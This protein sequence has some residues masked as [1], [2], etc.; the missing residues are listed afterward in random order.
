[1]TVPAISSLTYTYLEDGVTTVFSYPVRFLEASELL[2]IREAADGVRTTLVYNTDYT[3]SGAGEANG[4]SITRTAVTDGGKIIIGR[5]T[6][7]KQLVD[8][9]DAQRNPAEAVELQLDRLAMAIQDDGERVGVIEVKTDAI[10]QAVIDTGEDRE[11]AEAAKE[12]AEA[13]A[14]L[15]QAGAGAPVFGTKAIAEA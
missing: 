11:A 4:G 3:V 14:A 6:A 1:M 12:I 15:A 5:R 8:L 7:A 13:A 10:D 9:K 2:V